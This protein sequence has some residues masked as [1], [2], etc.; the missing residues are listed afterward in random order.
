MER[1]SRT[2]RKPPK[3]HMHFYLQFLTSTSTNHTTLPQI[4]TVTFTFTCSL[5]HGHAPSYAIYTQS[6][7]KQKS[8][9][10]ETLKK[11]TASQKDTRRKSN[12]TPALRESDI[13]F[14]LQF[15]SRTSTSTCNL[16]RIV[17]KVSQRGAL[18]GSK[19]QFYDVNCRREFRNRPFRRR[20]AEVKTRIACKKHLTAKIK[21]ICCCS[22][23][24]F[25]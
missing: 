23:A 10:T 22:R 2:S 11:K 1:H 25:R 8:H 21:A 18:E 9:Y 20:R 15:E 19:N 4:P 14:Y 7:N 17:K 6:R 12:D 3:S 16:H 13:H 24:R 5:G